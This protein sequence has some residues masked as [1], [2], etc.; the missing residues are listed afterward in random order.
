[1]QIITK[2]EKY[3]RDGISDDV[4]LSYQYIG[5]FLTESKDISTSL[6]KTTK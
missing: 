4:G 3:H 1:L 6:N 2:Y 5:I